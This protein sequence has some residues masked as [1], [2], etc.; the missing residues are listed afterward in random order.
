MTG[1]QDRAGSNASPKP[2][3]FQSVFYGSHA[4]YVLDQAKGT[5][6][7]IPGPPY[8]GSGS[9]NEPG[10][11]QDTAGQADLGVER[12]MGARSRS[13]LTTA[14]EN[15]GIAYGKSGDVVGVIA[16]VRQDGKAIEIGSLSV[17]AEEA[18]PGLYDLATSVL[19]SRW[20]LAPGEDIVFI[21]DTGS[22][23]STAG[24]ALWVPNF[25]DGDH[26]CFRQQ[27]STQKQE[28]L[29]VPAGKVWSVSPQLLFSSKGDPALASALGLLNMSPDEAEYVA[30]INPGD[31]DVEFADDGASGAR[32]TPIELGGGGSP[33]AFYLP[34]GHTVSVQ[35]SA[36]N[37]DA[38]NAN[39]YFA[40]V[41][42]EYNQADV[43]DEK[44]S[45]PTLITAAL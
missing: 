35:L 45:T 37:S 6:L 42:S 39:T 34:A 5:Q 16:L 22:G 13:I 19:G 43:T 26:I 24:A 15:V 7:L 44:F 3:N 27:L 25:V 28:V 17:S 23:G 11:A 29:K 40:A 8:P 41:V 36:T 31:G 18:A 1:L 14:S 21:P 20:C 12:Y 9:K 2:F 32:Y 33:P 4:S 30:F 38:A 10:R